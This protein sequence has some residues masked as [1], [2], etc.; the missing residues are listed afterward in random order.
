MNGI[1]NNPASLDP[2]FWLKL[3]AAMEELRTVHGYKLYI[4]ETRRTPLTQLLYFLQG[5]LS[6][7]AADNKHIVQ[8]YLKLRSTVGLFPVSETDAVNKKVTW[9]LDSRHFSGTAADI[10]FIGA[11]P[12]GGWDR[13]A[14]V[15]EKHGL[16]SGHR[17]P[18]EDS[19]HVEM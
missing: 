9:T 1:D 16:K 10:G 14:E 4:V 5:R 19:P 18:Q 11:V 12:Q 7:F 15:V 6:M 8:E 13:V 17:W 3:N 2:T